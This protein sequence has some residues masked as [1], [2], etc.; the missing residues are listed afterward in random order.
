M[1]LNITSPAVAGVFV[2]HMQSAYLQHYLI[3]EGLINP[4][5]N[6]N[7]TF[8]DHNLPIS[9]AFESIQKASGGITSAFLMAIAWMMV[10]DS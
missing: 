6:L 3:S 4:D 1:L 9:K 8:I 7:V 10:G 2:P 5:S